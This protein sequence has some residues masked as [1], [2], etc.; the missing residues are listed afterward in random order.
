MRVMTCNVRTS[1]ADDGPDHW[2]LRRDFCINVIRAQEADLLGFQELQRD[3]YDDLQSGL[4]E[5]SAWGMV[6]KPHTESP[7]NSVMFRRAQFDLI[8]HGGFWLSETP[9]ITGSRPGTVRVFD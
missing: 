6:D 7:V 9:H 8:S 4:P 1:L 2:S 5:F 3:Q